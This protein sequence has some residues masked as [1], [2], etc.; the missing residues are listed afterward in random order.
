MNIQNILEN[1]QTVRE[2]V[3]DFS[4]DNLIN[5]LDE[6]KHKLEEN[7]FYLVV[8]GLFKRGKSSVIN[9]LIG[10]NIAPVAITPVTAV[11]T[12]FEYSKTFGCE[13]IFNDNHR[14]EISL[15]EISSYVSEEE[16]P[17]NIKNVSQ[18]KVYSNENELLK[19][20]CIVDTPGLGSVF[21][22]NSETTHNYIPKIDAALFIL[23]ADIPVSKT[24]ADFL[25]EIHSTVPHIIYV[26]NKT[27]LLDKKQLEKLI[28]FNIKVIAEITNKDEQDIIV[29]PVSC[30]LAGE[31]GKNGNFDALANTIDRMI[32]KNKNERKL[33]QSSILLLLLT[34]KQFLGFHKSFPM[35]L[36]PVWKK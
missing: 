31:N 1:I 19:K 23:S 20:C 35:K 21:E 3:T 30:K 27:D 14:K 33:N 28:N 32:E 26:L 9:A 7:K 25:R 16:N 11:I 22:H 17:Q 18:I 8:T 2:I 10:K 24:D 34:I 12:F 29:V 5:E 4:D 15:S 13:V 6:L 36:F